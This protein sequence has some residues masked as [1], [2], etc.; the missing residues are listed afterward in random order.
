MRKGIGLIWA[1][2]ILLLVSF[3]LVF[4]AKVAFISSK[5]TQNSYSIQRAE[6]FMQSAIENT[7]LAIEGYDR[8]GKCLK[9]IHFTD[10]NNRF[11]AN[12]SIL[13]YYV[14]NKCPKNCPICVPIKTSFSNGYVLLKVSVQSPEDHIKLSKITLQ[15]P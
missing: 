15:R 5:H 10:E 4:I 6:L 7:L 13:R 12:V 8:K 14:Y 11:E 1:M 3:M 2:I 9:T